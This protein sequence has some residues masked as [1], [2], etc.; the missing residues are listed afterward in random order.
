MPATEVTKCFQTQRPQRPP[1]AANEAW[2]AGHPSH[3]A[4]YTLEAQLAVL[5]A[6]SAFDFPQCVVII[7]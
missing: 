7:V 4:G 3:E 2:A 5:S 1:V 6:I